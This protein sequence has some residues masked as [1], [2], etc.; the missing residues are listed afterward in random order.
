VELVARPNTHTHITTACERN[1]SRW[2][3]QYKEW[4]VHTNVFSTALSES[5]SSIWAMSSSVARGSS[6]SPGTV[7][8][9][10]S[11]FPSNRFTDCSSSFWPF[12]RL[13][14]NLVCCASTRRTW[15]SSTANMKIAFYYKYSRAPHYTQSAWICSRLRASESRLGIRDQAWCLRLKISIWAWKYSFSVLSVTKC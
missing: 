15:R 7:G 11:F 1:Q 4:I 2:N 6:M 5:L 3:K 10:S 13:V 12:S 9:A 8:I 14:S